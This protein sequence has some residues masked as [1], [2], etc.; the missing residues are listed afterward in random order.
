MNLLYNVKNVKNNLSFS[1][2]GC[3]RITEN[4]ISEAILTDRAQGFLY[5]YNIAIYKVLS[6]VFPVVNVSLLLSQ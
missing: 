5:N 1:Q 2:I 6:N 3:F 4:K